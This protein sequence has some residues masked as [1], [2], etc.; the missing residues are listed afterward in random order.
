MKKIGKTILSLIF[1][2]AL[3][4]QAAFAYGNTIEMFRGETYAIINGNKT[5]V[6]YAPIRYNK[7]TYLPVDALLSRCGYSLGWDAEIGAVTAVKGNIFS[8]IIVNSPVLWKGEARYEAAASTVI[9]NGIFY[10]PEDMFLFLTD[11]YLTVSETPT[12]NKY[13]TRDL[14]LDTVVSNSRR[15]TGEIFRYNNVSIVGTYG[16][17]TEYPTST[18]VESY[19]RALNL[20]AAT[21]PVGVNIY[22]ILVP[23]SCEFYGPEGVYLDQTTFIKNVYAELSERVIPINAV[24]TLDA[25]ADEYIYFGTDHHW[26]QRGAYYVYSEFAKE[27]GMEI[28]PLSSFS[29]RYGTLV[30]SFANFAKGTHCETVLR[31]NPDAF[32]K[33]LI[34]TVTAGA[35]Y[36]DMYMQKYLRPLS[37]VYESTNSYSA[38]I[39]GDN[40]LS[41]F[42]T[43]VSG[44]KKIVIL[45]ESFGNAFATWAMNNY[46]EVYVIDVRQF[47]SNGNRFKLKEFY[48]FVKF[49]DLVIINYPVSVT[50]SAIRSYLREFI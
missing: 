33:F 7:T 9:H 37:A 10:M 27:K 29:A 26:T 38:F 44:G 13:M 18:Y 15:K 50:S 22:N 21:A 32:E 19:A 6:G 1:C 34:P 43:N 8:Y 30:G 16:M 31:A 35:A 5:E 3:T 40:P 49:D 36:G 41:V 20:I 2:V 14:L 25:H 23:T 48:D 12:E 42:T 46:S 24:K 28:A 4:A 39:G 17:M 11:D 47:N 45:K